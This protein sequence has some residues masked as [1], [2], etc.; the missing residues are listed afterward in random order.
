MTKFN[1]QQLKSNFSNSQCID[2]KLNGKLDLAYHA[3]ESGNL[4][5]IF[6]ESPYWTIS[7]GRKWAKWLHFL[8]TWTTDRHPFKSETYLPA[9]S[10]TCLHSLK[11]FNEKAKNNKI[12]KK[13]SYHEDNPIV[14][15]DFHTSQ[16]GRN[17]PGFCRCFSIAI[18]RPFRPSLPLRGGL[19]RFGF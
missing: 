19:L 2:P 1:R 8:S 13:H 6:E 14:P 18:F 10:T 3:A 7:S 16:P 9:E 11:G 12:K 15:A 5:S 17:Q 4:G